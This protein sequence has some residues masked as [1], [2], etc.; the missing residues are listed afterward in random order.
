MQ[1]CVVSVAGR[2]GGDSVRM[3]VAGVVVEEAIAVGW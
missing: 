3:V 1:T 2:C